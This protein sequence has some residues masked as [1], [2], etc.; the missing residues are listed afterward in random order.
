LREV[1]AKNVPK[2]RVTRFERHLGQ[3]GV[4]P[5]WAEMVST[6]VNRFPHCSQ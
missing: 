6:R 2:S 1:L 5:L 4:R 3:G